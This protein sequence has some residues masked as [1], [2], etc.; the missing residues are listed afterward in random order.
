MRP[1][2]HTGINNC[3]CIPLHVLQDQK[4]ILHKNYKLCWIFVRG[5]NFEKSGKIKFSFA[6]ID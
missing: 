1:T 5:S 2:F 4:D 6:K 3:S